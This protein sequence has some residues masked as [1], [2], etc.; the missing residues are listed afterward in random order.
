MPVV[1]QDAVAALQALECNV[2]AENVLLLLNGV[3]SFV[4]PIF[5]PMGLLLL[6][7]LVKTLVMNAL[8]VL[9]WAALLAL[10]AFQR[11][12]QVLAGVATGSAGLVLLAR[13]ATKTGHVPAI[14]LT[15]FPLLYLLLLKTK[16][17]PRQTHVLVF[18]RH[19]QCAIRSLIL[20]V[21]QKV[22]AVSQE[23]SQLAAE[24]ADF[25]SNATSQEF[26]RNAAFATAIVMT[27]APVVSCVDLMASAIQTRIVLVVMMA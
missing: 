17:L 20:H 19:S 26:L 13:S 16:G 4:L 12:V 9:I 27:T 14:L 21:L 2:S 5:L 22:V 7:A 25:L 24:P 15:V 10:L 6:D 23:L 1:V 11:A 3:A 18:A 8:P